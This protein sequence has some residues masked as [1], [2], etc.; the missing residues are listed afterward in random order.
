MLMNY[1]AEGGD[2]V[3]AKEENIF[4]STIVGFHNISIDDLFNLFFYPV[5]LF[6]RQKM[7]QIPFRRKEQPTNF[8]DQRDR[9]A[10]QH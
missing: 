5:S 1:F 10:I 6:L 3:G 8:D 2:S 7:H 4:I 9:Y